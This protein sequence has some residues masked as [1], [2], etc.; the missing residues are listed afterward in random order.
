MEKPLEALNY[1][2][3][4][5]EFLSSYPPRMF[6]IRMR[7]LLIDYMH[8]RLNTGFDKDFKSFL[9]AMQSFISVLDAADIELKEMKKAATQTKVLTN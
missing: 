8:P 6:S 5:A 7:D 9:L 3:L 2:R 4:F 1:Q